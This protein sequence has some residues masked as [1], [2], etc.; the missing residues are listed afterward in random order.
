[1]ADLEY[2]W[3]PSI[4]ISPTAGVGEWTTSEEPSRWRV[5][6]VDREGSIF[7]GE[8]GD[9]ASLEQLRFAH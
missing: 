9:L 8:G 3:L 1:M 7:S 4:T 5:T 2:M 6:S